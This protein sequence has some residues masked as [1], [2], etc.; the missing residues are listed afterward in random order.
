MILVKMKNLSVKQNTI[1]KKIKIY[2]LK[3]HFDIRIKNEHLK[4]NKMLIWVTFI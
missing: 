3:M 4:M 1:S 2:L